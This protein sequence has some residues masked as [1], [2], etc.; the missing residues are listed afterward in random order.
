MPILLLSPTQFAMCID[1]GCGRAVISGPMQ[2][3]RMLPA[4]IMGILRAIKT[5]VRPLT[6]KRSVLT[7]SAKG[8]PTGRLPSGMLLLL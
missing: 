6:G 7:Q 8:I 4:H 2:L 3:R 5:A 1:P